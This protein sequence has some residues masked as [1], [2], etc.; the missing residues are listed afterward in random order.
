MDKN[1]NIDIVYQKLGDKYILFS[2]GID[3]IPNTSDEI[4]PVLSVQDSTKFGVH[5]L[6]WEIIQ[7]FM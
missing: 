4:Y 1:A 7:L 5:M 6:R 2:V 3:G